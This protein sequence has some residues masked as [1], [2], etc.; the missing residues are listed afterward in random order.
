M[1]RPMRRCKLMGLSDTFDCCGVMFGS[2]GTCFLMAACFDVEVSC[3][4]P[5]LGGY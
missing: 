5:S 2:L 1:L 4:A 3:M